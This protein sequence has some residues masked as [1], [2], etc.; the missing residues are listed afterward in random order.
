MPRTFRF[1]LAILL[2]AVGSGP[3]LAQQF[4]GARY[5]W[6][7]NLSGGGYSVSHYE[8]KG[9]SVVRTVQ[10]RDSVG[11]IN[12]STNTYPLIGNHF[13]Y[14]LSSEWCL[15]AFSTTNCGIR[16]TLSESEIRFTTVI[17]GRDTGRYQTIRFMWDLE[18]AQRQH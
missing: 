18:P 6:R 13:T 11:Y 17:D 15:E 7:T 10:T 3:S 14:S 5:V 9:D 8:I 12:T 4:N 1:A 2:A 16:G